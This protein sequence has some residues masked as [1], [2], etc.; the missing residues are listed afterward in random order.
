VK[1]SV[2]VEEKIPEELEDVKLDM[3]PEEQTG[4]FMKIIEDL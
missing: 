1:A 2:I 4:N 3:G